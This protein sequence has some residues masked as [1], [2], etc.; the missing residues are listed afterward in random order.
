VHEHQRQLVVDEV[1]ESP[2]WQREAKMCSLAAYLERHEAS[3]RCPHPLAPERDTQELRCQRLATSP[4][5]TPGV[6][7]PQAQSQRQETP[8]PLRHGGDPSIRHQDL[9]GPNQKRQQQ[10]EADTATDDACPE[11]EQGCAPRQR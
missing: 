6:E 2:E 9:N 10:A 7:P 8:P 1:D 4:P 3:R 5:L 11:L